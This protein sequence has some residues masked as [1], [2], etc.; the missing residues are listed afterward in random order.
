MGE[1]VGAGR[2]EGSEDGEH[3]DVEGDERADPGVEAG[4]GGQG[5]EDEGE[6]A[7]TEDREPDVGRRRP[8]EAVDPGGDD[9]AVRLSTIDSDDGDGHRAGDL[10]GVTGIDGES[11]GEEE[12]GREGVAQGEDEAFDAVGDRALGQDQPGHEGADG[13]GHAQLLGHAGDE[14]GEARRSRR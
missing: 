9:P 4:G 11:E 2:E 3:Q 7:P 10:A 8:A 13:V 6:L 12:H 5:G 1:R 14:H